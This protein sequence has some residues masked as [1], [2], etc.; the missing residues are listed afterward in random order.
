MIRTA[1][2]RHAKS[3]SG[4]AIGHYLLQ[5]GVT[6]AA[7]FSSRE[8]AAAYMAELPDEW[9]DRCKPVIGQFAAMEEIEAQVNA[10]AAE[11]Q[12][13]DLYIH[14][15]EWLDEEELLSSNPA[16]FAVQLDGRLRELFLYS[17][18][19]G[20][21]MARKRQ[22]QIIVPMLSD[23]LHAAGFPSSPVYNQGAV[24]FVKSLAKELAPFRVSVNA[25]TFGYYRDPDSMESAGGNRKRFDIFV[26]KPPV[27]ELAEAAKGLGILLDYGSGMSGQNINWGYGIPAIL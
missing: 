15:S 18:A 10:A 2:L 25:F 4:V 8:E 20:S 5:R 17:R 6:L 3:R 1:F 9:R 21:V 14:G 22:G 13:L 12:G 11:L 24:A 7:Q 16:Q 19:A 27:P 26:L 23:A